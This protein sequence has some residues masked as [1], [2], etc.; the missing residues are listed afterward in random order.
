MKTIYYLIVAAIALQFS[1]Y[2]CNN[3]T[4]E[5]TEQEET[6]ETNKVQ[7][8]KIQLTNVGIKLGHIERRAMSNVI[9]A[10][11]E[12]AVAPQDEALAA[13][14]FSGIIS[15]ICVIE[16]Q[17]VKAG[18]PV[19]YIE[20]TEI[21][22]I[23]QNYLTAAQEAELAQQE[24]NRQKALSE[25]GAG[26]R[27][28]LEQAEATL[29]I[30]KTRKNGIAQQLRQLG[31]SA[32]KVSAGNISNTI[33]VT[34]DISGIVSKIFVKTGSFADMQ[35]PVVNIVNNN[36]VFCELQIFEKSLPQ[37]HIG[38]NVDL[39]LTNSTNTPLSGIIT[40]I[41]RAI[42][43]ETR[44]INV[45]VKLNN[46]D[47]TILIPGMAV[48]ALINTDSQEVDALPDE[49][50]VTSGGKSYI[51]VLQGSN[52]NES[53]KENYNFVRTEVVEGIK[54]LGYTQIIPIEP[55]PESAIIAVANAFYL[56]SM[57]S[58]HGEED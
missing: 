44:T 35:T 15:R 36:A 57:A 22:A 42:D 10:N 49:A 37:V 26:V 2:S 9:H 30:A 50:V 52:K 8:N 39:K 43:P 3:S 45:R 20:N 41:N 58:D 21:V 51:F 16:G 40:D 38:Q 7:I 19:A 23:Q 33:A 17:Y 27:R 48:T 32:N 11:G 29:K 28:N 55:L 14:L 25:Q 18:Q 34:A 1:L 46:H 6:G 13:P 12:L 4:E 53:E 24:Y 5:K 54:A 56:N 47:N 31:I